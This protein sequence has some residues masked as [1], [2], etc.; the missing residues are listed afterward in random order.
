MKSL[1]GRRRLSIGPT[2][3]TALVLAALIPAL[4]AAW[5]LSTNSS[6]S[7]NT[8]AENAMSQAAHRVDVGALAHLGESHTVVNALVPPTGRCS[9]PPTTVWPTSRWISIFRTPALEFRKRRM[10]EATACS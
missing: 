9:S 7:I 8:L 1:S 4:L 2:L 3:I 6:Q 10:A 5:L